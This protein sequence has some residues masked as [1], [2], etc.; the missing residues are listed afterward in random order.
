MGRSATLSRRTPAKPKKAAGSHSR[1]KPVRSPAKGLAAGIR[2][3]RTAL[4]YLDTLPNFEKR[5][6]TARDR[7]GFTL[8]RIKRILTDLDNP[9]KD[10]RTVHIAGTKGKGS[11]AAMLSSMLIGNGMKVGLYTSPHIVDVRERITVN[12]H[13]ISENAFAK[14]VARVAEVVEKAKMEL[15]TFFE[16]L[17][18]VAFQYFKDQKVD[19]AVIE[20]GLGGR[21]DATNV[22]KPEV[23]GITN[24]SY[25]HM[26]VLGNSLE[27]IAGEKAGIFKENVPVI[28]APQP[29]GV[30]QVLKKAAERV[31]APLI[32]A[33]EDIEFSY[34]FESSR[35]AGPQARICITTPTS[36]FDH[37]PV[38]LVGEHQAVN[39]GV[40]LGM[41]DQLKSRGFKINDEAAISGLS[42]VSLV[43]RMEHL[44]SQPRVIADGAH[45]AASIEA[46]MRAIGQNVPYDSMVVIFACCGDKD[47]EGMLKLIQLGADKVIF[48]ELRTPRTALASDLAAKFVEVS[49]RMAQTARTLGDAMVIA[50]KAITR[51]DLIC[52]TG[53]FHLVADAK[54]Y[55]ANHPHRV[56][57]T[58]NFY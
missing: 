6:I 39:C 51:D 35:T 17:T 27:D 54:K 11:T 47:V 43:G 24:I 46:L 2:T 44:C 26:S 13:M 16:F 28:C 55:F 33:G 52:I 45:N 10:F 29:K 25:D 15:P 57:T 50:E 34:R 3:F 36:H 38:P 20:T 30:K 31:N 7:S 58:T 19:V 48:T 32:V 41:L 12:D 4:D 21:L 53:S 42:K 1:G 18:A 23:C 9:Q 56:T 5:S 49:G 22:I 37:L 8:S 14:T 40:A